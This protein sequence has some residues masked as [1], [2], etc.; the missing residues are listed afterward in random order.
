MS[1]VSKSKRCA[2]ARFRNANRLMWLADEG[3]GACNENADEMAWRSFYKKVKRN[4]RGVLSLFPSPLPLSPQAGR[5]GNDP[6][7]AAAG[8]STAWGLKNR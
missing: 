6:H 3:C 8:A 1:L 4:C 5:G 7:L 2:K